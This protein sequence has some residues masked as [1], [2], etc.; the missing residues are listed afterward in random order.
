M[1]PSW[2]YILDSANFKK[3]NRSSAV[4]LMPTVLEVRPN[5]ALK[6][7]VGPA[8]III[9]IVAILCGM[10]GLVQ[11]QMTPAAA[12]Q[13]TPARWPAGV[14]FARNLVVPTLIMT[15]HPRCP[16]SRAS[17]H[18]LAEVTARSAGRLDARVLF[19]EPA[20]A[21][22]DWLDGDLWRQAKAMP[23]VTVLID[24]DGLDAAAL[25]VATSGQ[26]VVYDSSGVSQFNGGITDGRGHEGDNAG[27]LSV[28]DLVRSGKSP[29][30]ATP[31]YGCSLGVSRSKRD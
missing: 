5:A 1:N 26:V 15:L 19:V 2:E 4:R 31:V 30:A 28:L 7:L 13:V 6:R 16:C 18:E 12:T 17:L 20:N 25:G 3:N 24:E 8:T 11:Y 14:R 10:H 22:A 21:G 23:N 29:R 9:W 27:L